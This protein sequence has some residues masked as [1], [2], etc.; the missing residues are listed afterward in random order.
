YADLPGTLMA[1][2]YGPASKMRTA[3]AAATPNLPW[4]RIGA[5]TVVDHDG[6]GTSSATPQVAAAAAIWL[7]D[8]AHSAGLPEDWRR[9]EAIRHALFAS[10][11]GG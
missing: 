7:A 5:P 11:R 3:I 2:N 6:S 1:G 4:A 9:V 10:A 8:S